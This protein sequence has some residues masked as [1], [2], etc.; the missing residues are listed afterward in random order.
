MAKG[1]KGKVLN[2]GALKESGAGYVTNAQALGSMSDAATIRVVHDNTDQVLEE[3]PTAVNR[4]L[5]EIGL[6]AEG[7]VM[8]YITEKHIID[9]GRLRNSITHAIDNDGQSAIVGTSVE[10]SAYVHNGVH[11][12]PG[13]PFLT[14][15]VQQHKDEYREILKEHL[16]GD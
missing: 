13:R 10:Y 12:R 3:F 4:A 2:A 1:N 15:P 6:V 16:S 9:T 8:G 11:G 5:E 14:D 7:H